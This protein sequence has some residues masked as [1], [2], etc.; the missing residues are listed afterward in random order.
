MREQTEDETLPSG[1]FAKEISG[2]FWI[3]LAAFLFISMYSYHPGDPTLNQ[4]VSGSWKVKNLIGPAGSYA[5]G[6]LVEMLGL[7]SWL[8]PFYFLFLGI[9]SFISALRQPWWRWIGLVLLYVCLLAWSSHPWLVEFQ[10]TLVIHEGGFIGA[11]LS[12]WSFKYLKPV[13][14]FLFWMFMTLAGI[15]LTLNLSWAAIGK[16][17]RSL[18]TDF[19]LKNKERVGRKAKRMQAEQKIKRAERKKAKAEAKARK[20]AD[21][22]VEDV[23]AEEDGDVLVLKPF[24]DKSAKKEKAKAKPKKPKAKKIDT[25]TDFPAL[26]FLAEPKVAGV[27]FDPKDLEEKTEALKVCLKDFNIDGEVQKVIPGPVV[28]MFE[29]RPAPGVKVSKIANLTDDL[30]LALKATAVR[31]EAPIPGKDSVGIEIPNDNRQTVY[32]REIFEHS[33]FTKSKSALTMALGKD[34][35]GEPVSADLAKMPHLLVAGATGAGKSVCLNGLLMS[36]LYKAGPEELKLLLIDPK[37]IELAVYASLPHLVHPVVTDMALAKS[38]LEWAVFEMDKRYENMARLGVRNIASYNEKLA[39]SGDDLPED[40]ED[41]EPMPYL[42]IIVDELADLMLTAGKDVE[43]SIVRLAQLARAAGIHIIL[44]TQRPSVDVVTGLIKANF[45]TR[46]SFQVTSKH[47]SRTILDMVGAEK[48]LGRGDMLFKP[49]GSKLRRLHG[50]LV[51]DDEIKGVVDFWKKKYPQDFE[52]DFTDWKDSGSSGPGAGSMPGES[53][54]PV[55][56]EAVEFVVGQGK[57]SISLLQRRFRIGFN[58]AA[59]FIEQMEQ[60]GILGPQDGSKPR[61][62]LVTKD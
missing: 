27:Q 50:A 2:L 1:K 34:I 51:E 36:M 10:K 6:I 13:G 61:I 4:A 19:W 37:R 26:D 45:P 24:A 56:N 48:L 11:L 44:A 54:D 41:L 60:D 23:D 55:Y 33:C 15:Q 53:D 49:S 28:T 12:K 47:D 40:L 25:S 7:G 30:A 9:T 16:R 42:V 46:I 43:I 59:R 20:E 39:K 29:F 22:E 52:L 14:A 8:I 38:A 58:R 32:L 5:A 57:A 3:F 62:V 18:L 21:S 31:I 35:Q 17:I